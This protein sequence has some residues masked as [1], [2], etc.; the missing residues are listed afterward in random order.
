MKN[1]L[2]DAINKVA[3]TLRDA[4]MYLMPSVLNN[5]QKAMRAEKDELALAKLALISADVARTCG[6][7]PVAVT[8]IENILRNPPSG[9]L[10]LL[11]A[12]KRLR[13]RLY[14][15]NEEI[16]PALALAETIDALEIESSAFLKKD[17][18]MVVMSKNEEFVDVETWITLAEVYCSMLD[19]AQTLTCLKHALKRLFHDEETVSRSSMTISERSHAKSRITD[20]RHEI[21][22]WEAMTRVIS[23]EAEARELL[24]GLKVSVQSQQRHDKRLVARI[25]AVL[26]EW[27]VDTCVAPTGIG[28]AEADR[29]FSL[30]LPT[31]IGFDISKDVPPVNS[32]ATAGQIAV[33]ALDQTENEKILT[34]TLLTNQVET[35]K[36]ISELTQVCRQLIENPVHV[37]VTESS[38]KSRSLEGGLDK[39]I[40]PSLLE[41]ALEANFTGY[42]DMTWDADDLESSIK[43]DLIGSRASVGH[44]Y[45]FIQNRNIVDATL[46]DFNPVSGKEDDSDDANQAI[47]IMLQI[48][49]A[50]GLDG[51]PKGNVFFR[52]APSVALRQTR[53]LL[54]K[55]QIIDFM[56]KLDEKVASP[57]RFE[58]TGD[59]EQ[60]DNF[61]ADW[62]MSALPETNFSTVGMAPELES[63]VPLLDVP[64]RSPDDENILT[65]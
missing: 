20:C 46:G 26:G 63:I 29:L 50:V 18:S 19:E 57:E 39:V 59:E 47:E 2:D 3:L 58:T 6:Q 8:L 38:N 37:P 40:L 48:S 15:D 5:L 17:A 44:G 25:N 55:D 32:E 13:V 34:Q 9:A 51:M 36:Q 23:G 49:M 12:A 42:F 16:A 28:L 1:S 54:V 53:V 60:V 11:S 41:L 33:V 24:G 65:L 43:A 27:L 64:D 10:K 31:P 52:H 61:D 14:L 21:E 22:F 56:I 30:G 4:Q 62:G 35:S 7:S 45:L